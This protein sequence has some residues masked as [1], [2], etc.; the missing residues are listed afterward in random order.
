MSNQ[1]LSD[2]QEAFCREY[3][4]DLNATQAAIRSGYSSKTAVAQ[5]SRL[6]TKV[7]IQNRIAELKAK[8]AE[9]FGISKARLVKELSSIAFF[10][11]RKIYT[12]DDNLKSVK[13]FDDAS[14]AAV[15]GIETDELITGGEY[16]GRTKKVKIHNKISAIERLCRMLGYDAPTKVAQ[17]DTKGK[18]VKPDPLAITESKLSIT[19]VN[20]TQSDIIASAASGVSKP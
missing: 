11:I 10:D 15:A 3:L 19:V 6:L 18:D 5:S 4:I 16:I 8:A 1:A 12:D 9:D 13:E 7:N 14:A 17:T 20:T 2:K